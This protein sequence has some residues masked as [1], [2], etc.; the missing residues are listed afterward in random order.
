[1]N[2]I[3]PIIL[4]ATFVVATIK[5]VKIYD[6]FIVGIRASLTLVIS[7]LPYLASIFMLIEIFRISGLSQKL[8][9][10]LAVPFSY[11]GIPKELIELLILRPLSGTGSLALVETIFTEYGVDSYVARSASVIMASN[12]TI[13][14]VIAV[15][16]S[17]A[18]DKKSGPAII[19]SVFASFMGA[20]L[21][22]FL[23]RF[24]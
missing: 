18:K 4:L 10:I 13:L 6:S 3:V 24:M 14:Y 15:Y 5:K 11:L 1:M 12:D 21:T 16:F 8:T 9:N 19:I 22:C 17:S 2:Y 7:L 23:C 20:I